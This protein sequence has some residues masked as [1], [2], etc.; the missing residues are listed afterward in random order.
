MT[1]KRIRKIGGTD[2][3]RSRTQVRS[4]GDVGGARAQVRGYDQ[5]RASQKQCH[6]SDHVLSFRWG[7][8]VGYPAE[9]SDDTKWH[10]KGQGQVVDI[11]RW[12]YRDEARRV[13]K[14]EW[15]FDEGRGEF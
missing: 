1:R 12:E 10:D 4:K 9:A 7:L 8:W 6:V 2:V 15:S 13:V 3:R 11:R 14:L 5:D